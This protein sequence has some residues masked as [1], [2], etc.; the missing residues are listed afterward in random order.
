M[1]VRVDTLP[2]SGQSALLLAGDSAAV[3]MP[4]IAVR[5]LYRGTRWYGAVVSGMSNTIIQNVVFT[6]SLFCFYFK[7][8]H[9]N[10]DDTLGTPFVFFLSASCSCAIHPA[11]PFRCS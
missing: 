7:I 4:S 1:W 8:R 5:A 11:H 10:G 9:L 3:F 2:T 6:F